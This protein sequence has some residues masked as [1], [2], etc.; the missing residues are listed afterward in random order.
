M[1]DLHF[2]LGR[3]CPPLVR[4]RAGELAPWPRLLASRLGYED[5]T[6]ALTLRLPGSDS[7]RSSSLVAPSDAA[8]SPKARVVGWPSVRS[9]RK[10]A[11]ADSSKASRAA[12]FVKVVVS[13]RPLAFS[14]QSRPSPAAP[15]PPAAA[16]FRSARRAL[17]LAPARRLD[18]PGAAPLL[19]FLARASSPW[20]AAGRQVS[21]VAD[22]SSQRSSSNS[23]DSKPR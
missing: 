10:N 13:R 4:A 8:P 1:A 11:L 7:G 21:R 3:R 5:T 17:N 15:W 23:K 20:P 16:L 14:R 18:L 12:N 2:S 19:I 6:L 22:I 9:Y